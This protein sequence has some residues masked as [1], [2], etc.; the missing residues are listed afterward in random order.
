MQ[1]VILLVLGM[2]VQPHLPKQLESTYGLF[3]SWSGTVT[4]IFSL[5][6]FLLHR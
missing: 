5:P 4:S 6:F 2:F 1:S 3:I